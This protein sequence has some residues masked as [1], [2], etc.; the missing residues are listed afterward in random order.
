MPSF[1]TRS[2]NCGIARLSTLITQARYYI[3]NLTA[4][5]PLQKLALLLILSQEVAYQ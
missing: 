1:K 2:P 5:L 3:L 4:I